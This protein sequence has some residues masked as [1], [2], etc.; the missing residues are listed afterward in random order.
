MK[1]TYRYENMT[2]EFGTKKF[3]SL[4]LVSYLIRPRKR[5]RTLVEFFRL[6]LALMQYISLWGLKINGVCNSFG[7]L[8]TSPKQEF[9]QSL[10]GLSRKERRQ[11]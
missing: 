8:Q 9:C 1:I 6:E 4:R 5:A 3:R 11:H 10:F 2:K 7:K